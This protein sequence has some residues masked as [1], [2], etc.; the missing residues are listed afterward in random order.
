MKNKLKK[1]HILSRKLKFVTI[2]CWNQCTTTKNYA[3]T[4][5]KT[6]VEF[7]W[8][9]G[10]KTLK[11]SQ[12]ISKSLKKIVKININCV[13]SAI[14]FSAVATGGGGGW[15]RGTDGEGVATLWWGQQRGG[16]GA[17][18]YLGGGSTVKVSQPLRT[19]LHTISTSLQ[20][21]LSWNR[22]EGL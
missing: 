18:Q 14:G 4:Y 5:Y 15:Q 17:G 11:K 6:L 3:V 22:A 13:F 1:L 20:N 21:S 8:N 19:V 2:K 12:K 7:P 16:G 10:L 9:L